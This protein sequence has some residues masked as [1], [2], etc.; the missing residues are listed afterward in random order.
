M[1]EDQKFKAIL[2]YRARSGLAWAIGDYRKQTK[3]DRILNQRIKLLRREGL[4]DPFPDSL[5]HQMAL[6][7]LLGWRPALC[8][9]GISS[10]K[11]PCAKGHDSRA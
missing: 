7:I 3:S 10:P 5:L 6:P 9:L 1:Q 4:Q 11:H 2:S 8:I